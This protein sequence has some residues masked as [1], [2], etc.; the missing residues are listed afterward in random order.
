MKSS[1]RDLLSDV[2]EHRSTLKNNQYTYYPRLSFTPK[3]GI[4]FPKTGIN[5]LVTLPQERLQRTLCDNELKI[6]VINLSVILALHY[7]RAYNNSSGVR[8]IFL[9]S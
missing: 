6:V 5:L 4:A 2:T 9:R 7:S 3:T 1:R 8:Q